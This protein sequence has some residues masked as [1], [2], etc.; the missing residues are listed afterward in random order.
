M[1]PRRPVFREIGDRLSGESEEDAIYEEVEYYLDEEEPPQQDSAKTDPKK[2]V[3]KHPLNGGSGDR[4][5]EWSN[6]KKAKENATAKA[7]EA[8]A[9]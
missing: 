6:K 9:T 2:H 1:E 3:I 5:A 8:T 4:G 7:V